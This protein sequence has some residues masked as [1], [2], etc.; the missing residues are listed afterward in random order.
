MSHKVQV[1][2]PFEVTV[3]VLQLSAHLAQNLAEVAVAVAKVNLT[4]PASQVL[5][6]VAVQSIQNSAQAVHLVSLSLKNL[7]LHA[8][9][10]VASVEQVKQFSTAQ[11][12]QTFGSEVP[13]Y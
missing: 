11:A 4:Y 5:Q 3:Q 1:Y 6:V 2:S 13:I 10:L 8:V 9:H 7:A 12:L